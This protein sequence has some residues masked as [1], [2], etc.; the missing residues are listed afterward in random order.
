MGQDHSE[1]GQLIYSQHLERISLAIMQNK[2]F[3]STCFRLD[4]TAILFLGG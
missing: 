1:T 3:N 2:A 4:K